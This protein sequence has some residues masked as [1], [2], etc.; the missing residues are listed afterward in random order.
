MEKLAVEK[1]AVE[2]LAVEKP[3][4]AKLAI[5]EAKPAIQAEILVEAMPM[6]NDARPLIVSTTLCP[7]VGLIPCSATGRMSSCRR[8]TL[9][10]TQHSISD[11]EAPE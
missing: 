7:T 3:A 5:L 4:V 8:Q 10:G 1:L 9:M 2:K 11:L 6:K